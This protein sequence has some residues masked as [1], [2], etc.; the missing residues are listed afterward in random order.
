MATMTDRFKH[1]STEPIYNTKAVVQRTGIPA[2]TLRAWE[3]RYGIPRPSRTRGRHRAYSERDVAQIGWLRR[4]TEDG[5]SISQ[6]VALLTSGASQPAALNGPT[7]ALENQVRP[8]VESLLS[9]DFPQADTLISL[10]LD[11]HSIERVCLELFQPALVLI[12]AGWH[13]GSITIAQ[14]HAATAFIHARLAALMRQ[15]LTTSQRGLILL[16]T[17]PGERHELGLM[18]VALF[19]MRRGWNIAFLGGDL[20]GAEV[21]ATAIRLQPRLVGVSA[22]GDESRRRCAALLEALACLPAGPIVGYGGAAYSL[23]GARAGLPGHYLGADAAE[24]CDQI[25]ALL[26]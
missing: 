1:L 13:D 5:L 21:V 23:P 19:L 26:A 6:A 18:M 22:A 16:A 9:F 3:R 24:A 20:P 11:L 25:E 7:I 8:L 14:E 4:Q 10:A 15:A 2:D 12:G 17:A